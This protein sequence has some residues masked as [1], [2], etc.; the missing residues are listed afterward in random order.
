V[1]TLARKVGR[2]E[3]YELVQANWVK[4]AAEAN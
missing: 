3:V 4:W 2:A 1:A